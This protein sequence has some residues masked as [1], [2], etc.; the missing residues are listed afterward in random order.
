MLSTKTTLSP[1]YA[2]IDLGSNSF[3]ML[4]ASMQSG[5]IQTLERFSE[6]VQLGR[7]VIR[8]GLI[9]KAAFDRG[10]ACIEQFQQHLAQYPDIHIKVCG[11]QALR[12]ARNAQQFLQAIDDIGFTVNIIAGEEEARLIYQG[13]SS[14][15]NQDNNSKRLIIDI[16]GGSTEFALGVGQ[17]FSAAQS[18]P[19]G[20]IS[21]S[22]LYFPQ[23][24]I[25]K[26]HWQQATMATQVLLKQLNINHYDFDE[27]VASSGSA[28]LLKNLCN[29]VIQD[30]NEIT[31]L[32]LKAIKKACFHYRHIDE[33]N[34]KKLKS[35]RKDLLLP[36]LSIMIPIMEY[37]TIEKIQFSK[38]ALR[39]G[40][41]IDL[42]QE[43]HGDN[44]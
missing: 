40:I 3:H 1:Y 7:S 29:E 2:S 15:L 36:G 16:G 37:L 11:T 20:C 14:T 41:V 32:G 9:D 8:S 21:W 30:Q 12:K 17:Q 27:V 13:V 6:K 19:M 5:K 25:D 39:E 28:K 42:Y 44:H 23:G 33:L 31:L 18:L 38:S 4:I 43:Q 10:I 34:F 22:E 35:H 24:E 26:S